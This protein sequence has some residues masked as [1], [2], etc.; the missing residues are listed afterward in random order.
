MLQPAL[1]SQAPFALFYPGVLAVSW[2]G[3]LGPGLLATALSALAGD[4]FT[5]PT[6]A[7][8]LHDS[9]GLIRV[10]TFLVVASTLS[11]MGGT[12]RRAREATE[13]ALEREQAARA[14]AERERDF[15]QAVLDHA[16]L[17]IG[18]LEGPD[19]RFA[20]ANRGTSA[21]LRATAEDLL[22]RPY[23]E[24]APWAHAVAAPVLKR[25]YQ[26]G[27]PESQTVDAPLPGGEVRHLQVSW[28]PLPGADGRPEAVLYLALDV[29][30]ARRAHEAL[31]TTEAQLRTFFE[32]SVLGI[33]IGDLRGRVS[34]VN[35]AFLGMVGYTREEMIG[36]PVGLADITPPEYHARDEA[37][38]AEALRLGVSA[39]YEKELTRKDGGRLPA[40]VGL[41]LLEG[42]R[43]V[44]FVLDLTVRKQAERERDRLLARE[45]RRSAQL[46]QLARASLAVN[47]DL[48]I[49]AVLQ[50]ITEQ[51]ADIIGA[52]QAVTSMTVNQD[53]SQAIT[54]VWLSDKYAAW[55]SY[56]ETPDGTGIYSLVCETNR[57][58]RLTQAE[59]EA[60]PAWRGF[61]EHAAGHP[62]MRGWLAAPL[63]RV[64]GANLGLIQLSDKVEG[65]FTPD[66]EAILVQ[67]AQVASAAVENAR[68]LGDER[69]ARWEAEEANRLKDE[70]L[71]TV[72]HELRTPLNSMLGWAR[73]LRSGRLDDEAFGRAVETIERNAKSQ[74]QLI[75]DLLDVSRIIT[76]KI[77]INPRPVD[78]VPVAGAA[79]DSIRPAAAA[80]GIRVEAEL[81]PGAGPVLGD[82][83]RLQQVV[84]NLVSNAVKFTPQ[85]GDLRVR[86]ASSGAH[87]EIT[88]SDTGPGIAPEFLPYVFDRFR[89]AD[90]S[91]TR[92]HGGLGLGLAITRHLVELHGGG[93][94]VEN[95]ADGPGATFTVTLPLMA[96]RYGGAP[97]D[98]VADGASGVFDLHGV[99]VLVVDDEG[100]TRALL[101]YVLGETGA[102]ARAAASA[103]E[104]LE[105]MARWEPDVLV[106][107][108]GMPGEDGYA[109]IRKVRS[110][111]SERARRVPAV[112]V[113]AY[114]RSDDRARL[115]SAGF[116]DHLPKPIEPVDL[117]DAVARLAGR[118]PATPAGE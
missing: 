90:S 113:T 62:P 116:Q 9:A 98:G 118:A 15:V 55:R 85:G 117:V 17:A 43:A 58:V 23:A 79:V 38:A 39:P 32:S 4:L 77:R 112:A 70:F 99:K 65:D 36:G 71:A 5:G 101:T 45:R 14:Q 108:V 51:A 61:G 13:T 60:H 76:G 78:L 8:D 3:G 24:A 69:Q 20:L 57:P 16:P 107:D 106:S 2:F 48:T 94:R 29:S 40:L 18:V 93:I 42:D 41:T 105:E 96:G 74:A 21:Q 64:G 6:L 87:A 91:T 110:L 50:S 83:E 82:P 19:H 56:K 95:H 44:S 10:L 115:L 88:V 111:E 80:K 31:R 28:A 37:G 54:A 103:A 109:L 7:I 92:T 27:V 30:E 114:A 49:D 72:S 100:D 84:W 86:L 104:A 11:W 47:A 102:D 52:H 1:G 12:L 73:L 46:R 63:I 67:L 68:L 53:W 81:D 66:D 35:D 89:Q 34:Q 25:V 26:T 22:G 97:R 33:V 59:L 75:E